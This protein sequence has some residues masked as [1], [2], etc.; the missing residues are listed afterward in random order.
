MKIGW[1]SIDRFL[2]ETLRELSGGGRSFCVYEKPNGGY[3]IVTQVGEH[4]APA[5]ANSKIQREVTN[6]LVA[7]NSPLSFLQNLDSDKLKA[8]AEVAGITMADIGLGSSHPFYD[9]KTI[10]AMSEV[11]KLLQ[12]KKLTTTDLKKYRDLPHPSIKIK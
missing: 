8:A 2:D 6:C 5:P 7:T 3:A 11:V 10:D 4:T 1:F 12:T 9:A